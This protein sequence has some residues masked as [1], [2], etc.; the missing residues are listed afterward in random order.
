MSAPKTFDPEAPLND[1]EA[2]AVYLHLSR[3]L[4]YQQAREGRLPAVRIGS[5]LMIKTEPLLAMLR[6]GD[7]G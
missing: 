2:T 7:G 1:C 5:R 6:S 3:G 4:I